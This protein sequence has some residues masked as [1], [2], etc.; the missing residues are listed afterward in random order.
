MSTQFRHVHLVGSVPLASAQEVFTVVSRALGEAVQ[1]IPDGET[2]DR[3]YWITFQQQVLSQAE[4]I[5]QVE[6]WRIPQVPKKEWVRFGVKDPSKP[7]VFGPLRYASEAIASYRQFAALKAKG[8]IATGTRFQVSLPTPMAIVHFFVEV[9][10]QGQIESAYNVK[11]QEELEEIYRAIP[12][13]ELAIQWDV[14]SEVSYLAGWTDFPYF[15]PSKS[16]MFDKL[17][18][19]GNQVRDDVQVGYHFCYGDPGHK[20]FIEP[21]DLSLSVEFANA[22]AQGARRPVNFVHMPVPKNRS[23]DQYFAPL[24]N[25]NVP[26]TTEVFLGLIHMTDGIDGA[27]KRMDAA[28]RFLPQFGVATECGFGRRP[29]ATVRDLLALHKAAATS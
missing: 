26:K 15:A 19:L 25:L 5:E 16:A 12:P 17:V 23:D 2:G 8:D 3:T 28:Q 18:K 11:L 7:A 24:K 21:T 6:S 4:N 29:A 1:R 14:C 20:H 9:K 22:V 10:S 27:R 13:K